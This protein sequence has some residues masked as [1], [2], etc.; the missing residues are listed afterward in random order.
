[1]EKPNFSKLYEQSLQLTSHIENDGFLLQRNVEQL[2]QT[3]K[4]LVSKASKVSGDI[5]KNKAHYLLAGK[6]FDA[7]RLSRNLNSINIKAAFEPA[8]PLT[9][10]DLDAYLKHEYDLTILTSIEEAKKETTSRFEEKYVSTMEQDWEEAKKIL[11]DSDFR[12]S[13]QKAQMQ[14]KTP[15]QTSNLSFSFQSPLSTS[16][17][18]STLNTSIPLTPQTPL[19]PQSPLN[20]SSSNITTIGKKSMMD[21]KMIRYASVMNDLVQHQKFKR[22]YPLLTSFSE[23]SSTLTGST[24]EMGSRKVEL[25]DSWDILKFMLREEGVSQGQF[26]SSY[27]SEQVYYDSYH[28]GSV[29]LRKQFIKGS[30]RFLEQQYYKYMKVQ[31]SNNPSKAKPGPIPATRNTIRAFFK[32]KISR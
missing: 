25:G 23:V 12:P 16:K 2:D 18:V 31:I 1:M 26:Q 15:T 22:P 24:N 14:P 6:G 17:L 21:N 7:D 32:C 13:S 10:T 8:E 29:D 11:L 20:T 28:K 4:K 5:A 3:S 9:E 19:Y 27:L 30:L